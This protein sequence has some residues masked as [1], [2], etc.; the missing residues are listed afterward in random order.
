MKGSPFLLAL[1]IIT[2]V[3]ECINKLKW[4]LLC[5]TLHQFKK[6]PW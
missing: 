6:L 4:P 1:D 2:S 5:M 3:I